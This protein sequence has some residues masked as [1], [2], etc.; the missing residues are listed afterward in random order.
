[1]TRLLHGENENENAL[2]EMS[3][4]TTPSPQHEDTEEANLMMN[5][6]ENEN[7]DNL[8]TGGEYDDDDHTIIG[9]DDDSDGNPRQRNEGFSDDLMPMWD[10]P[11]ND[12]E[13]AEQRRRNT[14][15]GEI[16]RVQRA[17]FI[18]FVLLCL[19]PTTLLLVVVASILGEAGGCSSSATDCSN[20]PREFMNAFTTRCICD[21]V[22]VKDD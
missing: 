8:E 15:R 10:I 12:H 19:V 18:H 16:E 17:N 14:I 4:T 6:N 13:E 1:M 2:L 3:E 7:R 11:A 22:A 20:E 9:F 21:A 5:G